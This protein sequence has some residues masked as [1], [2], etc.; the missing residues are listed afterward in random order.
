MILLDESGSFNKNI[1]EGIIDI[2]QENYE[3]ALS[4]FSESSKI[5]P[6]NKEPYIYRFLAYI[7][8]HLSEK[9]NEYFHIFI[10]IK[11][12]KYKICRR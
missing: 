11:V 2:F 8:A 3:S 10:I 4:H 12:F 9:Q 5:F 6:N 7:S 1:C